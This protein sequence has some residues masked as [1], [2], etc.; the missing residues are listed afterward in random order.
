[1]TDP[2]SENDNLSISH[3][4][5]SSAAAYLKRLP[6]GLTLRG[7]RTFAF[8]HVIDSQR[9][10]NVQEDICRVQFLQH[11]GHRSGQLA[12][13]ALSS[14]AHNL[15]V[16]ATCPLRTYAPDSQDLG[17]DECF[18]LG[19]ISAIQY[20]DEDAM[21]V[22]I[23]A[24]SCAQKCNLIIGSAAEYASFMKSSGWTL[25]PI[26]ADIIA[27]IYARSKLSAFPHNKTLQ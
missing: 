2:T 6:E 3:P 26:S 24:L 1:M 15:G 9:P 4:T 16:C 8:S 25:L 19:L 11:L 27:E 14:L 7:Y 17:K 12:F 22:S 23:E 21:Y 20:G 13:H 18:L 10:L 5:G